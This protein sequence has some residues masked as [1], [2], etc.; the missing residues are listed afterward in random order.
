MSRRLLPHLSVPL[1]MVVLFPNVWT[2]A[3]EP[4]NDLMSA[5]ADKSDCERAGLRGPVRSVA[6][7]QTYPSVSLGDG[8]VEPEL[9][10]WRKTE[11]DRKGRI[12]AIWGRNSSR[13]H[14]LGAALYVTR[15]TYSDAGQLMRTAF[16]QDGKITGE[17]RYRYDE[18]GRLQEI[19]DSRDPDNPIAFRYD[20]MGRKTKIAIAQPPKEAG[21]GAV[22]ASTEYMFETQSRPI[23][24]AEGGSTTTL[25]DEHDR[26][27]EIQTRNA[28]GEIVYRTVRVY[29]DHGNVVEEKQTM[30]DPIRIIP[31]A[32]QK[33]IID[34][35]GVSAQELRDQIAQVL[36]GSEM[37]S[38]KYSYDAEGRQTLKVV[39]A[40]MGRMEQRTETAFNE[41]GDAAKET[42][43]MTTSGMPEGADN[44]TK[45]S[46]RT[47]SYDYD[48]YGNWTVK[49]FS[50]RSL[51]DGTFKDSGDEVRRTI[52]Y[53]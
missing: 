44:G 35:A 47:Y 25:Y 24:L 32:E 16:E 38:T 51:P 7:E 10:S 1:I 52:E 3:Q 21:L 40:L 34:Q 23:G 41:H 50:S 26:P 31:P 12:A 46:E 2:G 22:S 14:G 49:K 53:Y 33:K 8:K 27:T 4:D 13:E 42:E 28:N 37:G 30:D 19:T 43:H 15:Y 45:A 36:G 18:K 29:D 11:Y 9:K 5:A 20:A 6:E 39:K 48:S 17:T